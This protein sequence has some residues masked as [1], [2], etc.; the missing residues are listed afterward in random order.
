L[1]NGNLSSTEKSKIKPLPFPVHAVK[2]TEVNFEFTEV[3]FEFTE[4]YFEFTEVNFEFMEVNFEFREVNFEFTEVNFEFTEVNFE[5]KISC[6]N[7]AYN[8]NEDPLHPLFNTNPTEEDFKYTIS[9]KCTGYVTFVKVNTSL[10]SELKE[11]FT[12]TKKNP[13]DTW[14]FFSFTKS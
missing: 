2:L 11:T 3:N 8:P 9:T 14:N 4:V 5:F 6:N 13:G 7:I 1:A 12:A 10:L